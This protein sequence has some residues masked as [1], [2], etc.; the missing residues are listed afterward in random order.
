MHR[1][2]IDIL[3]VILAAMIAMVVSLVLLTRYLSKQSF[4]FVPATNSSTEQRA[5]TPKKSNGLV[6]D[7][8]E[9]DDY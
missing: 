7:A 5:T 8:T 9:F 6:P 4:G 1:G 2:R 3:V